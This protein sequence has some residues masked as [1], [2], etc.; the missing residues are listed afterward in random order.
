MTNWYSEENLKAFKEFAEHSHRHLITTRGMRRKT[1]F[2]MAATFTRKDCGLS[3]CKECEEA[4]KWI[5]D[6]DSL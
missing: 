1:S 4:E 2:E 6:L 3:Y 5:Y